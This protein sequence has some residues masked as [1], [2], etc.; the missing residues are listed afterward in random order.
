MHLNFVLYQFSYL[1]RFLKLGQDRSILF[2]TYSEWKHSHTI[3]SSFYWLYV[4]SNVISGPLEKKYGPK[5]F[6]LGAIFLNCVA[7]IFI[8]LF[9]D[10]YGEI[11]VLVCRLIQGKH[12]IWLYL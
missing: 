10:L 11:G 2:Q 1:L 12:N 4:V 3:L 9:A 7:Y 8:P 5:W 6:F